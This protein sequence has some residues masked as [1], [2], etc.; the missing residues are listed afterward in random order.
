[1]LRLLGAD[2]KA[3]SWTQGTCGGS[4]RE[5][6]G[7]RRSLPQ[8]P[9]PQ[10]SAN[11]F[12]ARCGEACVI[13][14][15]AQCCVLQLSRNGQH[16]S[17]IDP[18]T[19]SLGSQ[20]MRRDNIP[21]YYSKNIVARGY[22]V[23]ESFMHFCQNN[24]YRLKEGFIQHTK[25]ATEL[26]LPP[27][28]DEYKKFFRGQEEAVW[29]LESFQ[30]G[31]QNPSQSKVQWMMRQMDK[32]G[33]YSVDSEEFMAFFDRWPQF[34]IVQEQIVNTAPF[35]GFFNQYAE[36]VL[37]IMTLDPLLHPE[38]A[39]LKETESIVEDMDADGSKVIDFDEFVAY[40]KDE[41]HPY[42]VKHGALVPLPKDKDEEDVEMHKTQAEDKDYK[43]LFDRNSR[44]L[45]TMGS[46]LRAFSGHL[47]SFGDTTN[48][49]TDRFARGDGGYTFEAVFKLLAVMG[50]SGSSAFSYYADLGEFVDFCVRNRWTVIGK[51]TKDDP[52][53]LQAYIHDPADKI[54]YDDLFR[55]VA[56]NCYSPA[57]SGLVQCN[58]AQKSAHRSYPV[59][60]LEDVERIFGAT[61]DYAKSMIRGRTTEVGE[62]GNI[63]YQVRPM[64]STPTTCQI[65]AV[66]SDDFYRY[67]KEN[68]YAVTKI[69]G[70]GTLI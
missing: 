64:C 7:L 40:C 68:L 36:K 56:E 21:G 58:A 44:M 6:E 34:H 60:T 29:T 4:V 18:C 50:P 70:G 35:K 37:W 1:M 16:C 53:H 43:D 41:A 2:N 54:F 63:S 3:D 61:E 5:I 66:T 32:D 27:N 62:A 22:A 19:C 48:F 55:R 12:A 38:K 28:P 57:T 65:Y 26:A 33:D 51:G 24:P 59:W 15:G 31:I 30:K 17:Q 67:C 8:R 13:Q 10:S 49:I 14:D 20:A 45:L 23:F 11:H 52:Y 47:V 69:G 42:A 25:D 39:N 46:L 9:T